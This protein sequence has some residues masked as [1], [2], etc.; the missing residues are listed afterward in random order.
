MTHLRRVRQQLVPAL[1]HAQDGILAGE[2]HVAQDVAQRLLCGTRMCASTWCHA[3]HFLQPMFG[4]LQT[5]H[6]LFPMSCSTPVC[7]RAAS[8]N[9]PLFDELQRRNRP[10]AT[11]GLW[12]NNASRTGYQPGRSLMPKPMTTISAK[13]VI[14]LYRREC[15]L[16][17]LQITSDQRAA[18]HVTSVRRR[19]TIRVLFSLIRLRRLCNW[20]SCQLLSSCA[21]AD[22]GV[23]S[24]IT[25]LSPQ[26]AAPAEA[27][28]S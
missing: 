3:T 28:L 11:A 1:A 6:R 21:S 7:N 12:C 13:L 10:G 19:A 25:G 20:F 27:A 5:L 9:L 24:A 8:C 26:E 4:Q 14:P 22:L 2:V 16:S 23:P 17:V 18:E 15:G